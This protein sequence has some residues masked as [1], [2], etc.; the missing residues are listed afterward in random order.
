MSRS[1]NLAFGFCDRSGE[2][3]PLSELYE[4]YE[5][6]VDTGLLVSAEMLDIDH[7]QLQ[8]GQVDANDDQT[9]DDPRPDKELKVSRALSAWNPVG[10]G[11][12]VLGSRT[13]GM[14]MTAAVG[15]V[16]IS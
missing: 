1:S 7:E 13:V 11:I 12:T 10:G 4:Q 2:R 8:I 16:S 5:N 6:Q 14:D 15:I 9:L 3:R